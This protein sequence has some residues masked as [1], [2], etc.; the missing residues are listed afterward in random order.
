MLTGMTTPT[1]TRCFYPKPSWL[2]FCLLIVE[3]LLWLSEQ[4]HWFGFNSHKGWIGSSM[5]F[6]KCIAQIEASKDA[7][8]LVDLKD[9]IASASTS[10]DS[11]TNTKKGKP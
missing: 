6:D 3:C 2:I 9:F 11:S 5:R 8:P 4:F 7:P 1:S 10:G